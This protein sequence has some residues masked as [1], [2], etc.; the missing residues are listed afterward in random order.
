MLANKTD[1]TADSLQAMLTEAG[2]QW[3]QVNDFRK[4][5]EV[6]DENGRHFAT[7]SFRQRRYRDTVNI[8]VIHAGI[9]HS[10]EFCYKAL[11]HRQDPFCE[12]HWGGRNYQIAKSAFN[13]IEKFRSMI[14][15]EKQVKVAELQD[16]LKRSMRKLRTER[17]DFMNLFKFDT[18]VSLLDLAEEHAPDVVTDQMREYLEDVHKAQAAADDISEQLRVAREE[19]A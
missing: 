6:M 12:W 3:K 11:Q 16:K 1:I 7:V 19:V 18:L 8:R 9:P 10:D 4:E 15:N 14:P 13:A 2:Y 5:T 17:V